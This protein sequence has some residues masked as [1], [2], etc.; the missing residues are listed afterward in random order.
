MPGGVAEELQEIFRQL[1]EIL[2]MAGVDKTAVCSA[3]L[4]L[5]DVLHDIAAVNSVY[6]QY[7]GSHPPNRRAYGVVLQ[8]GMLVEAAFIAEVP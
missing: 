4:Y 7:F 1:D 5:A 2:A 3:R 6:K 8:S